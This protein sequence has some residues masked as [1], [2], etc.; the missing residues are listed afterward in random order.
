MIAAPV[1]VAAFSALLAEGEAPGGA[2]S[3]MPFL[4]VMGA[5]IVFMLLFR[6]D[7]KRKKE[8]EK[9]LSGLKRNDKILTS[10]G[11]YGTVLNVRERDVILRIDD[12]NNIRVRLAK[13]AILGVESPAKEEAKD[14]PGAEEEK[15]APE[16]VKP[17]SGEKR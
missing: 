4:I 8:R 10:G 9:M 7:D 1:S 16:E 15:P 6:P 11:I 5:C 13:T 17:A 14:A 12:S 3:M 2:G